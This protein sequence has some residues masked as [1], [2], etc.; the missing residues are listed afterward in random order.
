VR[1]YVEHEHARLVDIREAERELDEGKGI[2][3][4]QMTAWIVDLKAGK[5][6][7]SRLK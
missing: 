7:P 4:E 1:E 6:R 5:G 2:P 3:H